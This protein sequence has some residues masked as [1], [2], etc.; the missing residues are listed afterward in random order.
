MS[1]SVGGAAVGVALGLGLVLIARAVLAR[2]PTLEVR[3]R[4]YVRD[5]PQ[6]AARGVPGVRTPGP[7]RAVFG[8]VLNIT[9]QHVRATATAHVAA[10]NAVECLRPFAIRGAL[11]A[12]DSVRA[13]E[14]EVQVVVSGPGMLPDFAEADDRERSR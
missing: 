8:P 10:G 5:L 12:I 7:F 4:P 1:V 2:R 9:E 6:M 13:T 3:V 11:E 14:L